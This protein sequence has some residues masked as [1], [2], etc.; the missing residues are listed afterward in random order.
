VPNERET[1]VVPRAHADATQASIADDPTPTP[2]HVAAPRVERAVPHSSSAVP[3]DSPADTPASAPVP[4]PVS[5]AVAA[6]VPVPV[7]A[8]EVPPHLR[9]A[10]TKLMKD[11]G[12]GKDYQ[13]KPGFEH[14]EGFLPEEV[15]GES[16]YA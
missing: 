14:P 6:E 12:Y 16:F 11:Q 4:V 10:P 2:E 9:N 8:A 3:D 13:W 5:S 7:P 1:A 15:Q